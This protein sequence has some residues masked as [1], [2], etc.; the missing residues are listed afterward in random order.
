MEKADH[1]QLLQRAGENEHEAVTR[2]DE[3]RRVYEEKMLPEAARLMSELLGK[4]GMEE[5]DVPMTE[6]EMVESRANLV[7]AINTVQ[8]EQATETGNS[9]SEQFIQDIEIDE[10]LLSKIKD[11]LTEE[12][13]KVYRGVDR[14]R[15]P[16]ADRDVIDLVGML[17][18]YMLDHEELPNAVKALLSRL[19]TP[20]LKVAIIDKRLFTR[21]KHPAR[22]LLDAMVDAGI[23]YVSEDELDRGIFPQMKATVDRVMAEFTDDLD[24]FEELLEEFNIKVADLQNKAQLI[25]KRAIEAARGQARLAEARLRANREITQRLQGSSLPLRVVNF[26]RQRMAEKLMFILL[27][28]RDGDRSDA[29]RV[30]LRIVDDVIWS[31]DPDTVRNERATLENRLPLLRDEIRA[32]LERLQAYGRHEVEESM[33]LILDCQEAALASD[34]VAEEMVSV[35]A[36]TTAPPEVPGAAVEA[37]AEPSQAGDA[38]TEAGRALD[39]ELDEISDEERAMQEQLGQVEFG[40]WFEFRGPAGTRPR[41]LKLAWFS[42]ITGKYMFVDQ[43]GVKAAEVPLKTLAREMC[44]G[45]V[46]F[47]AQ[48]KKPFIDRALEAVS[49][50]L[51]KSVGGGMAEPAAT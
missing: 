23:K 1:L 36:E 49:G 21:T 3:R 40:T 39:A 7:A 11:T 45:R 34:G 43:I 31:T 27:R 37:A 29:W 26:L 41:R 42:R 12:R 16:T 38:V 50:L 28:E 5:F 32:G 46:R 24:L 17:F 20:F 47:V 30:A 19:H 4:Q 18:E 51:R 33:A 10:Q 8:S 44:Q 14:R 48:H 15:I 13:K 22:R 2:L 9:F 6:A 35:S 25:E